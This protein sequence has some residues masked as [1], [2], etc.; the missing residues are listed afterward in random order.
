M[1]I[2][3]ELSEPSRGTKRVRDKLAEY[4]PYNSTGTI[5]ITENEQEA[6]LTILHVNGR[7]DK[8]FKKA[9][10]IK[11]KGKKYAVIQY[12]VRSTMN[13]D[14]N[15]WLALWSGAELVWSYYDLRALCIEDGTKDLFHFYH[16]PLGA[17]PGLFIPHNN[18]K[19]KYI[20]SVGSQSYLTES[21][22]ECILAAKK[23]N[24][25]VI[26]IGDE[27]NM[28]S[29]VVCKTNIS[30]DY[31]S[32]LYSR[33]YYVSG[34]RRIE[35]FELPAIEGLLCGSRP[36]LFDRPHY[37]T[38]YNDFGVFIKEQ[39]R[40]KTQKELRNLFSSDNYHAVSKQEIIEARSRFNWAV[41][42]NGFWKR[43][44]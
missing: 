34:L 25:K 19:K 9:Y 31:L 6:D 16:A 21:A 3:I 33:S 42:I 17:D 2:Y 22:K 1:N 12:C 18:E 20:I 4:L 10:E 35:G 11:K 40:E 15:D 43:A 39:D 27:L 32:H 41:I 7:R 36:V 13:P 14:T 23:E 37:R 30:D 38:W 24:K 29:D 26:Y 44:L 28:G 8:F 5:Q